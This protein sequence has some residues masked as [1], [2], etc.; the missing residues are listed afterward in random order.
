[1]M[2]KFNAML[3][4]RS[5]KVAADTGYYYNRKTQSTF[6]GVIRISGIECMIKADQLNGKV[7]GQLSCKRS[8]KPFNFNYKPIQYRREN[9][10][11]AELSRLYFDVT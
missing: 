11:R 7:V 3:A 2:A 4:K 10:I 9:D 5:E 6:R 1:M 8:S